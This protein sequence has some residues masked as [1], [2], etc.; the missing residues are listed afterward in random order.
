[1]SKPENLRRESDLSALK[2][3]RKNNAIPWSISPF[4]QPGS[5]DS[6]EELTELEP[7]ELRVRSAEEVPFIDL[8]LEI[9]MTTGESYITSEWRIIPDT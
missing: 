5:V 3:E 1:M 4:Q 6:E 7:G 2:E 9:A 8:L